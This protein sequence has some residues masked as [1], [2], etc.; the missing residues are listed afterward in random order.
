M[1]RAEVKVTLRRIRCSESN[2]A[3]S[4]LLHLPDVGEV[5]VPQPREQTQVADPVGQKP[6]HAPLT[7]VEPGQVTHSKD[8]QVLRQRCCLTSKADH[9]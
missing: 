4:Q 9:C 6:H 8:A 3:G 5:A 7:A 1:F 2:A